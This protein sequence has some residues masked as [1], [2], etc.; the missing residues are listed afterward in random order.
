MLTE[1]WLSGDCRD[2]PVI[3]EILPPAYK[4]QEKSRQGRGGGTA[5]IYKDS[6]GVSRRNHTATL[7]KSF[8]A[9]SVELR[10]ISDCV[11][12]HTIYRPPPSKKNGFSF[13]MLMEEFESFLHEIQ[14]NRFILCGDLNIHL[15]D[16]SSSE[17]KRFLDLL[18]SFDLVQLVNGATH[19]KGHTL[20]VIIARSTDADLL[21][22][23]SPIDMCFPDHYPV[24]FVINL[25]RPTRASG[26]EISYR[27][28]RKIKL[29]NLS[30]DIDRFVSETASIDDLNHLVSEYTTSMK[31]IV[32]KHAPVKT[33]VINQKIEAPWYNDDIRAA[34]QVRRRYEKLWRD[35]G[36]MVHRQMFVN[37]RDN[38]NS[39][40]DDA[41]TNFY[42]GMIEDSTS[43][44]RRLFRAVSNLLGSD[45]RVDPLSD[46]TP[47]EKV[48]A[49][50]KFFSDKIKKIQL[51][52][53]AID[54]DVIT[55]SESYGFDLDIKWGDFEP[56]TADEVRCIVMNCPNKVEF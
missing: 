7:A 32:D 34:K 18:N 13:A 45:T 19:R 41:K 50:A 27:Q 10:I 15:D 47:S 31:S 48:E 12:V 9:L 2:A 49:F 30:A 36:L 42:T 4:I 40:I 38:V 11:M 14:F 53:P 43:D 55:A 26:K 22:N 29:D 46:T 33:R 24:F 23:V 35:S 16:P 51:G 25:S 52:F 5:I 6:I 20:D 54:T 8:E 17:G 1:T 44:S 21:A 39:M 3:A 56:A 28:I 37:Q